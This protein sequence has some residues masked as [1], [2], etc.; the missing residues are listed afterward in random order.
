MEGYTIYIWIPGMTSTHITHIHIHTHMHTSTHI[1]A[2]THIHTHAP[3]TP[4]PHTCT[5]MHTHIHTHAHTHIHMQGRIQDFGKGSNKHIHTSGGRAPPMG[6]A[7][8][9]PLVT[10]RGTDGVAH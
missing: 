8:C 4:H 3:H 6:V 5:H 2:Y 10:A 7:L 9:A 1:Y